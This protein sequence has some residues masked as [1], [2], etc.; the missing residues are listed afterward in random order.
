MSG[1]FL[2]ML[3]IN[4]SVSE[5]IQKPCRSLNNRKFERF[6]A[7]KGVYALM[8]WK[9]LHEHFLLGQIIDA[10][11]EGCRICYVADRR[12]A[13]AFQAQKT[14]SLRIFGALKMVDLKEN[15]VVHDNELIR[16]STALIST[17]QCGIKFGKIS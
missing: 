17:R 16:Y 13:G 1:T 15:T 11:K 6:W 5:N 2:E 14:F 12:T 4:S 8:S 9:E 7:G 3:A 10:G